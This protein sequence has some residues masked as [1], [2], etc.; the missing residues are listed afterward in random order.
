MDIH[1][2]FVDILLR[3]RTGILYDLITDKKYG[4]GLIPTLENFILQLDQILYTISYLEKLNLINIKKNS[5][6]LF[7][8]DF[9]DGYK[10]KKEKEDVPAIMYLMEKIEERKS[11]WI[12]VNPG[13]FRFRINGYMTDE[14]KREYKNRLLTIVSVIL[15]SFLTGLFTKLFDIYL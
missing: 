6:G 7:I 1:K 10:P 5:D 15:A 3:E 11:W 14:E 13:L 8:K 12:E 2:K 4:L 9:F